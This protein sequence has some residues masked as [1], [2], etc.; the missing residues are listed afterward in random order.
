MWDQGTCKL[1]VRRKWRA[2]ERHSRPALSFPKSISQTILCLAMMISKGF[3]K[4][5]K[6]YTHPLEEKMATNSSTLAWII[7]WTEE[8][9][10]LYSPRGCRVGHDLVTEYACKMYSV[11]TPFVKEYSRFRYI[12][13]LWDFHIQVT[14]LS[15]QDLTFFFFITNSNKGRVQGWFIGYP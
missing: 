10:R 6:M 15:V 7:P 12:L 13:Y 11:R 2:G 1:W 9:G 8:P 14:G 3:N 4:N 5:T